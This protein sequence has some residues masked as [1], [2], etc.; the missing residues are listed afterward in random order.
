MSPTNPDEHFEELSELQNQIGN[1]MFSLLDEE[2]VDWDETRLHVQHHGPADHQWTF[3]QR[4]HDG[5][6]T[7]VSSNE[8]LQEL[9]I[10]YVEVCSRAA[11]GQVKRVRFH[12]GNDLK[13]NVEMW[14]TQVQGPPTWD[15]PYEQE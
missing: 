3:L 13:F 9:T 5:S 7:G 11:N 15:W 4:K 12:L 1:A 8:Q 6:L 10:K 2:S 14:Y